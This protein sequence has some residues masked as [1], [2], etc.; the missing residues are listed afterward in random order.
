[1][2]PTITPEMPVGPL[3]AERPAR[4]AVLEAFGIDYCCGGKLPLRWFCTKRGLD[5]QAVIA[6][7]DA[8]RPAQVDPTQ[9]SWLGASLAELVSHLTRTHHAFLRQ[10]FP[11]LDDLAEAAIPHYGA[12]DPHLC[13]VTAVLERFWEMTLPHLDHEERV[14]FPLI[15][16][17]ERGL[18]DRDLARRFLA[19]QL[20]E[21]EVEHARAGDALEDLRRLADGLHDASA[22]MHA[23]KAGLDGLV[24]DTHRHVHKENSILFPRALA[25]IGG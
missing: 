3:V 23:L 2:A 9:S 12:D 18:A 6:A 19:G 14:V 25:L 7:L 21:L 24:K 17:V 16:R 20:R 4:A 15:V 13:R 10:E 5:V 22:T 8:D 11:R 1:M